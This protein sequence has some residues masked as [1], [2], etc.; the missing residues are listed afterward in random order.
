MSK[1]ESTRVVGLRTL[2]ILHDSKTRGTSALSPKQLAI[3]EL[4]DGTLDFVL[5]RHCPNHVVEEVAVKELLIS[6][7][8]RSYWRYLQQFA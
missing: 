5:R 8:I 7:E 4:L 2:Q 3:Q 6:E 1:F